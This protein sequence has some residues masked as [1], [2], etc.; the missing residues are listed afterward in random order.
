MEKQTYRGAIQTVIRAI[1]TSYEDVGN[2]RDMATED[3][4]DSY[5]KAR[6]RLY[7][8]AIALGEMDNAMTR[9]RANEAL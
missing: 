4:K 8:A 5:N 6:G 7:D 2:L 9:E 3:E 1:W